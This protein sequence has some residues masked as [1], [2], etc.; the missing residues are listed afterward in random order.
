MDDEDDDSKGRPAHI[1]GHKAGAVW[2]ELRVK[3]CQF[4]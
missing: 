1:P 4:D 2:T 3:T